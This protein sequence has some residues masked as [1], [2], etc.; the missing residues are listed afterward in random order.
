MACPP[1]HPAAAETGHPREAAEDAPENIRKA[2]NHAFALRV[3]S[4]LSM[5][6]FIGA[7]SFISAS[8]FIGAPSFISASSFI[9]VPSFHGIPIIY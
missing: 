9:G 2:I 6:S 3:L 4:F 1:L 5:P 8:S 7:P